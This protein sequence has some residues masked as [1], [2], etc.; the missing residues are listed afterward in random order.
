MKLYDAWDFL[1][2]NPVRLK[3][4][5]RLYKIDQMII[6]ELYVGYMGF[7]KFYLLL[8]SLSLYMFEIS[9][10]KSYKN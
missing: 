6:V 9:H 8:L 5:Y 2:N 10:N 1:Y 3:R 4:G 7:F